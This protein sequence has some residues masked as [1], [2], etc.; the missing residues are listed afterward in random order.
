M[1]RPAFKRSAEGLL[2]CFLPSPDLEMTLHEAIRA[3]VM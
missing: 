1:L 3:K 2:L